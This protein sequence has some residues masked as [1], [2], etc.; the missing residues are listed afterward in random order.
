LGLGSLLSSSVFWAA[1]GMALVPHMPKF[2]IPLPMIF[3]CWLAA[4]VLAIVA[5]L[6][7]SRWWALACLLPMASFFF[8][9]RMIQG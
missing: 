9:V 1:L 4:I 6:Q 5:A 2:R 8:L 3:G 7:G